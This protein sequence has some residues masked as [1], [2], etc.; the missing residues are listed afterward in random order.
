MFNALRARR[1]A[2]L[3]IAATAATLFL[4][5]CGGGDVG[6]GPSGNVK[7]MAVFGDSLSDLGTYEVG[8]VAAAGGGR[9]TTNPAKLWVE[10]V[11]EAYGVTIAR[12]RT[13]GFGAPITVTRGTGYAEGGARVVD[14]IGIGCAPDG[15]G[16]CS[17]AGALTRP[18]NAQVTAHLAASGGRIPGDQLILVLAGAND[19]LVQAGQVSAGAITP[20]AAQAAIA[21]VA[22]ALVG[23]V[24]KLVAAGAQKVAVVTSLDISR[25]PVANALVTDPVARASAQNLFFALSLTFNN[26]LTGGLVGVP[27]VVIVPATDFQ[28]DAMDNPAKYGLVNVTLPACNIA[29]LPNNSSLFCSPATLSA[30]NANN[31]FFY[32][33]AVHPTAGSTKLFGEFVVSRISAEIPR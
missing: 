29:V 1:R 19:I 16:S 5:S 13:G 23:E 28:Y 17:L 18:I 2:V 33:D 11:A 9:F 32:A 10:Y 25:A 8:P 4:M 26:A 14:P 7:S 31:V 27:G 12:N 30:A 24:K 3:V 22:V 20:A 6:G 15:A 21:G